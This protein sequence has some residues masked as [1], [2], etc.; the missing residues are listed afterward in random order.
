MR[1]LLLGEYNSSH[2]TLKE[3]LEALNHEVLVVGLGDGFKNRIVDINI[4]R[5]YSI[6][7]ASLIKNIIYRLT[8]I[9]LT[10]LQ[11]KRQFNIHKNKFKNFDI[12]Q[13]VNESS[14]SAGPKIE[15]QLLS[16]IFKH[17]TN[18]FLLSC[19]TDYISVKYAYLKKFRYSILT[20]FFEKR[21]SEKDFR[22][23]LMYIKRPYINLHKFIFKNIKGVI[24]SDLDYHIPLKGKEKYL[25]MV[26]N[27][28]NINKFE[29][30]SLNLDDKII[31]FHGINRL[32]YL[33]KGNNIFEDA[34]GIVNKKYENRIKIITVE[35]LPYH[36]YITK[37]DEAHILLDQ[38]YAYDQGFNALEAMAKGKVV[39][40]GAEK[41]WLD[42][43]N[44]KED[45]I[46]INA[47]PN[48]NEIAKKL[49]WLIL[50]PEEITKISNNARAFIEKEHN[51]IKCAQMYLDK[52][53]SQI[54]PL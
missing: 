23:V 9:D 46:A 40:T 13:L 51:H 53:L 27:P 2:Y 43:Y 1:I 32:N 10:A 29:K 39:F 6:G 17:N 50:N 19:G 26:P 36:E 31:I 45:T 3:G 47:L 22:F 48:A 44:L 34:L 28:I 33:K 5:Y 7:L 18:I 11:T 14:F 24:A 30:N 38:V 35:N 16:F 41:E 20:P 49:E 21:V 8:S 52:W 42:Y 4:K 12:V 37:F 15:T 25:G 54:K